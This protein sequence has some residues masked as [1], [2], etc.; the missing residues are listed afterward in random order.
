MGN[1][2]HRQTDKKLPQVRKTCMNNYCGRPFKTREDYRLCDRCRIYA[3]SQ[4][5]AFDMVYT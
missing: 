1:P 5:S 4:G 2:P 3:S